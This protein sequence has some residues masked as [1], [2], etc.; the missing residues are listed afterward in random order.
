MPVQLAM[1]DTAYRD[2]ELVADL[3]AYCTRLSKTQMVSVRRRAA[4]HQAWL[5]RYEFA[6]ILVAQANGFGGNPST[7]NAEFFRELCGNWIRF[8]RLA[9]AVNH[10]LRLS[11]LLI[12]EGG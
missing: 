2:S 7:T 8:D 10:F 5:G 1:V 3:E 12:A 6:V 4:A 11:R 9:Q